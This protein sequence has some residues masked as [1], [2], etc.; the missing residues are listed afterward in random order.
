MCGEN[1]SRVVARD[2]FLPACQSAEGGQWGGGVSAIPA[3]AGR[4]NR[5]IFVSLIEK[6]F[7]G[8]RLKKC[9]ENFSVLL[10][11]QAG[12][13]AGRDSI[14]K[15]QWILLKMGLDFVQ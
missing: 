5:K 6:K 4:Q 14:R 2:K 3:K 8:A 1:E 15:I 11:G 13:N 10:S 12:G 7:G 9:R